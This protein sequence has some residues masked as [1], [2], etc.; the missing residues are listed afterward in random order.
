[1]LT[2]AVSML[3]TLLTP[4]LRSAS[5]PEAPD[6]PIWLAMSARRP[7]HSTPQHSTAA[8]WLQHAYQL[9]NIK[10]E[11]KPAVWQ[12]MAYSKENTAMPYS[13]YGIMML[14]SNAT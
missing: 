1:M 4:L 7:A 10:Q 3:A 8:T 13:A 6:T 14:M 5:V 9:S 12:Q 2:S 11:R